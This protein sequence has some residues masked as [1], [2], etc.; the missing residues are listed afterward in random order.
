V[1]AA[2]PINSVCKTRPGFS[3]WANRLKN[4]KKSHVIETEFQ[5]GVKGEVGHV[6]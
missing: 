4:L 2:K 6:Q 3:A 1:Q 5:P